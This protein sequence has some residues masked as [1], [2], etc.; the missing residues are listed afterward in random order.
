MDMSVIVRLG[1]KKAILCAGEWSCADRRLEEDLQAALEIWIHKTG[2]PPIGNE[3][4]DLYAAEALRGELGLEIVLR[5]KPR[6]STAAEA[7]LGKR[8]YRLPFY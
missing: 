3:D 6:R 7:Y 5:N 2:G 4:P 8:Q 1:R